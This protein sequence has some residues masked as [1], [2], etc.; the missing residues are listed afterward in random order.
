MSKKNK[1]LYEHES[2]LIRGAC[3]DLYKELGCGHK[4]VIYQRGLFEKMKRVKLSVEREKR[5][6]VIVEGKKVGEY[7]PDFIIHEE[8]LIELKA[9]IG[10]TKHDSYQFWQYLKITNLK[11]GFLINFGKPGGVEI[12]RIVYDT[13]RQRFS[14]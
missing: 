8:I 13:A 4:E 7:V 9:S 12:V 3:F 2:Y 5:I 10:L 14:A 6:P 1:L 11:L